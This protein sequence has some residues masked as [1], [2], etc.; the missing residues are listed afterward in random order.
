MFP[1]PV[2]Q[3]RNL[4][5]TSE[6]FLPLIPHTSQL[7]LH[8][9]QISP[10]LLLAARVTFLA[11]KFD[12]VCPCSNIYWLPSISRIKSKFSRAPFKTL[13]NFIPSASQFPICSSVLHV[14][15]QYYY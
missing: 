5:V 10:S 3:A 2:G 13:Y 1:I 9:I 8:S 12:R 11:E 7:C 14:Q 6:S 15:Q 4:E